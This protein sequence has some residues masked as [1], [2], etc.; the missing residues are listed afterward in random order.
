V[1]DDLEITEEQQKSMEVFFT[2]FMEHV[3]AMA[4]TEKDGAA[5]ELQGWLEKGGADAGL[6]LWALM[7][8]IVAQCEVMEEA[9][10]QAVK[11]QIAEA[12]RMVSL[13]GNKGKETV[14]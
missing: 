3:H 14:H 12:F 10:N 11:S 1:S 9:F 13:M 7:T 8:G 6:A 5:F 4:I 2:H